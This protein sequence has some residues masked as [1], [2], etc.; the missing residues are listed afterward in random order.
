MPALPQGRWR[1]AFLSGLFIHVP[2]RVFLQTRG[3]ENGEKPRIV[4][5]CP[6]AA[7]HCK[8]FGKLRSSMT[9]LDPVFSKTP[10]RNKMIARV[11]SIF[12]PL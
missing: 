1:L 2:T 12:L 10:I 11:I 6:A 7:H 9:R 3:R 5:V 4:C 8:K